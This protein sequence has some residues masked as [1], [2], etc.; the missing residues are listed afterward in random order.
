M[1]KIEEVKIKKSLQKSK[2]SE[3]CINPYFGC[4]NGCLYCYASFIMQK[5]H[6]KEEIWGNFVDV[7]VNTPENLKKEIKNKDKIDVYISSMTDPYQSIEEKYK[8]TRE[9]LKVFLNEENS[10]F[11][12]KFKITVQTKRDLI[13][14]DIDILKNL[15]DVTIGFTIT[16]MDEEKRKIFERGASETYKRLKALEVFNKNNIKTYAFFGPILPGISDREDTIYKIVKLIYETGTRE[17]LFDKLSYF[18]FMKRIKEISFNLGLFKEFLKSE[19]EKYLIE[20]RI[21]IQNVVKEF[22]NL[23]SNILF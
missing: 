17:I 22:K 6:H 16:I 4:L 18:K 14:R 5:W 20:L 12:K 9:I 10:L 19:D 23:H 21:K 7:R 3:Y 2:I 13:L 1:I 15:K 11:D 8:L